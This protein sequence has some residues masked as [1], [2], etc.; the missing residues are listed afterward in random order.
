MKTD[1]VNILESDDHWEAFLDEGTN[2]HDVLYVLR[3]GLLLL[4]E[5]I[6][7]DS[8]SCY[9]THAVTMA[10]LNKHIGEIAQ[11]MAEEIA[12]DLAEDAEIEAQ[13]DEGK[14]CT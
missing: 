2:R 6:D 11:P 3:K 1:Y 13:I 9:R 4:P 7:S 10:T 14:E 12:S 8:M 5:K